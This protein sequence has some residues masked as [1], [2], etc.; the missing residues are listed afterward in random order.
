MRRKWAVHGLTIAQH[1][2]VYIVNSVTAQSETSANPV[3]KIG[4]VIVYVSKVVFNVGQC[5][6]RRRAYRRF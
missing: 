1:Y 2:I 3:H 5:L 4:Y 6:R